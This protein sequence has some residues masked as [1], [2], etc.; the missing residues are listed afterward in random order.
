MPKKSHTIANLFVATPG[1]ITAQEFVEVFYKAKAEYP[2]PPNRHRYLEKHFGH[3]TLSAIRRA[4][5]MLPI[6]EFFGQKVQQSDPLVLLAGGGGDN[7]L[8]TVYCEFCGP[9]VA[10][11]FEAIA[12][13]MP[14]HFPPLREDTKYYH[15]FLLGWQVWKLLPNEQ[16]HSTENAKLLVLEASDNEREKFERLKRKFSGVPKGERRREPIVE[17]VRIFVWRRD[18]G[19]CV[20]CGSQERLEYD[21]IIPFSQG[22]SSTERN[23]QLLCESCNRKKHDSI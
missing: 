3:F 21:H 22:G 6:T 11:L 8:P 5:G 1:N 13:N 16:R 9:E 2:F 17:S 14:C 15:S 23:I 19:R 10:E 18:G 7:Y 20:G 12:G 4:G